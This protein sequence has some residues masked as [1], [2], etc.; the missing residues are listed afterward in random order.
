MRTVDPDMRIQWLTNYPAPYRRPLWESLAEHD[1]LDV[2]LLENADQ[3]R[4]HPGNRGSDWMITD[5]PRGYRV[6]VRPTWAIRRGE[7]RYYVSRPR[8]QAPAIDEVPDVV[9]L[10]GWESPAYWQASHAARRAGIPR[11]AFYESTLLSQQFAG[12]PIGAVRSRFLRS[13]DA[14]VTPGPSAADA[15]AAAGVPRDAIHVGFN[16]VDVAAIHAEASLHRERERRHGRG[17]AYLF[18]GQLVERKNPHGALEAFRRIARAGDRFTFVGS[19]PLRAELEASTAGLDVT[20]IDHLPYDQVPRL[21]ARHD[22][23]VLPSFEEVWGLV[24]NEALAAGIHTVTSDRAG[25]SAS[26]AGM[27]GAF[28]C[29]VTPS[30]I[31]TG[32]AASRESWTGPI[33]SPEI[34]EKTPR[35]FANVFRQACEAAVQRARQHRAEASAPD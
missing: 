24:A 32:M 4:A 34:L 21:L 31:A 17:H 30:E 5:P 10:G 13:M 16:A 1:A 29:G 35:A 27:R 14:V 12:G 3:F 6:F 9:V 19:G 7:H 23:L 8:G 25:V 2:V 28:V 15:V 11:V 22:T 20:F 26:V 18:L 33:A